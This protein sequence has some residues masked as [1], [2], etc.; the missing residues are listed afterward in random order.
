MPR[1]QW[2]EACLRA[3]SFGHAVWLARRR[4]PFHSRMRPYKK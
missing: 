2:T 3:H 4:S 1:G